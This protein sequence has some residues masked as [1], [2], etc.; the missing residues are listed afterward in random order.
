MFLI[1]RDLI[2]INTIIPIKFIYAK[3]HGQNI[4]EQVLELV[5]S[6]PAE[7]NSIITK[8][9]SLKLSIKDAKSSQAMIQLKKE[10]CDKRACLQCAIGNYLLN[11]D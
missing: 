3:S 7:K 4:A 2:L 1:F 9:E 10:Y 11:R 8:F 5:R 6:L